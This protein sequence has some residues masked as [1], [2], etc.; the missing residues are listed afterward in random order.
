MLILCHRNTEPGVIQIYILVANGNLRLEIEGR[1]EG[2][3]DWH[4]AKCLTVVALNEQVTK[5]NFL[6]S[7]FVEVHASW[8]RRFDE[9]L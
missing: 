1:I 4:Q 7:R 2:I 8:S 9:P 5:I 6:K 3:Y